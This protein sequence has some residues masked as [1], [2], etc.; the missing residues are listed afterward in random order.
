MSLLNP[1]GLFPQEEK[2]SI[3][4]KGGKIYDIARFPM[5]FMIRNYDYMVIN[6]KGSNN[7]AS[8]QQIS[9]QTNAG[10]YRIDQLGNHNYSTVESFKSNSTFLLEQ[11]GAHNLLMHQEINLTNSSTFIQQV[12]DFNSSNLSISGN[13]NQIK[14]SVKG[15]HNKIGDYWNK[16]LIVKGDQVET[17]INQNGTHNEI[18]FN[19]EGSFIYT[20]IRQKGMYNEMEIYQ[21]VSK[22]FNRTNSLE[23]D[24]AGYYNDLNITQLGSNIRLVVM[25]NGKDNSYHTKIQNDNVQ[26]LVSQLGNNNNIIQD[27]SGYG[28]Q[29]D[30]LQEGN[31]NL[32]IQM[33]N[34]NFPAPYTINQAGSGMKLLLERR[35]IK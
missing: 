28:H 26:G 24:Q 27:I 32:V 25:Q 14:I 18:T 23:V 8:L 22:R 9:Y 33:D 5:I 3:K 12:G 17:D 34:N 29:Y 21:T 7:I 16:G 19:Q 6:Q 35:F 20:L 10:F 15:S 1:I 2:A 13:N 11:D 31:N 30:I 4:E